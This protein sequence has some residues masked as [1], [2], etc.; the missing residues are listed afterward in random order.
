MTA[1]GGLPL[2]DDAE[3]IFL[4]SIEPTLVDLFRFS[5]ATW[6]THRI[7][8]DAECA[9][10]EGFADVV[11]QAHLHGTYMLQSFLAW[12]GPGTRVTSYSWR[13]RVPV[14]PG[15]KLAIFGR[16]TSSKDQDGVV[17][18]TFEVEERLVDGSA[19]VSGLIVAQLP[20]VLP[21]VQPEAKAD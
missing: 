11:L 8:F 19:A 12:A 5:A 17:T 3:L 9:R 7:H 13:N 21:L 10:G 4:G 1:P 14:S 6:N 2:S 20:S 15:Q 18:L 16:Q